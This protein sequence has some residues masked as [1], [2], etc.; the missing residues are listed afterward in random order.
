MKIEATPATNYSK[1]VF[2]CEKD[3]LPDTELSPGTEEAKCP[4]SNK[5]AET[6][7]D[8]DS[9]CFTPELFD[10]VDTNE[11][12]G[13]LVETDRSSHS[14]DCFSAEELFETATGF[15]QK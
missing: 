9:E 6:E 1:Q 4:S 7:V 5:A 12:N 13:E 3:L 2:C 10:P 15:G 14:S 8:D 11:E